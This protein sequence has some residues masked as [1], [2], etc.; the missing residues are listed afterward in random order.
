[1]NARQDLAAM[2]IPLGRRLLDAE[3]P[4]LEEHSLSMWGY[5]VL[6]ALSRASIRGQSVLADAIGAD[7][8]R[9]IDVLDELQSRGLI[10][11]RPDPED[12]RTRELA[13]TA[14]GRRLHTRVQKSI[15]AMEERLLAEVP[16]DDRAA[17]LR[18]LGALA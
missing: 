5:I 11:R 14:R 16:A 15:R 1:M 3:A 17:F 4:I 13:I 7:K 8:T 6:T 10:E 9:I 18:V 12:R 2:V